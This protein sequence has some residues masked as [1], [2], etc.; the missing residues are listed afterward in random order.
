[1]ENDHLFY[2]AGTSINILASKMRPVANVHKLQIDRKINKIIEKYHPD[3]IYF[4]PQV[5]H[6]L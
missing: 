6:I 3:V 2:N 1:M 5:K 4:E